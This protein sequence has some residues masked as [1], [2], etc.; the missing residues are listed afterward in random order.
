M[1]RAAVN[2]NSR[3]ALRVR[4][5]DKALIQRAIALE[6]TDMTDFIIRTALREAQSVIDAHE[7]LK[8]TRRD[9]LLVMR[10]LENPPPPNAKLLKAARAMLE[11]S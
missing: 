2:D 8:L 6:Q 5:A 7:R 9:S 11:R 4:P 1:P 10:L 3:I